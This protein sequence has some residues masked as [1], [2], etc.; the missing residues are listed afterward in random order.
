MGGGT[1]NVE[2]VVAME[3]ETMG[4]EAGAD[5][6]SIFDGTNEEQRNFMSLQSL[7]NADEEFMLRL[8]MV[9]LEL[10]HLMVGMVWFM[11]KI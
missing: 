1:N 2:Q 9:F 6:A 3:G 7:D 8:N 4:L 10:H 11:P 5:F